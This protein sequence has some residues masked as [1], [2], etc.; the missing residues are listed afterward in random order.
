MAGHAVGIR[1]NDVRR[2][3]SL[4]R[5][6]IDIVVTGPAGLRARYRGEIAGL[7]GLGITGVV[8]GGTE[9][10]PGAG[11]RRVVVTGIG[12]RIGDRGEVRNGVL[13]AEYIVMPARH[14]ARQVRPHVD[15]VEHHLEVER[16]AAGRID[17]T[18]V[19]ADHAVLH[20]RAR[21]AMES[22]LVVA[23]RAGLIVHQVVRG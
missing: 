12:L 11:D 3:V 4:A 21:A 14:D 15:L 1:G 5:H 2:A 9:A 16:I 19:V 6:E 22:E 18:R 7:R 17:G 13:V 10:L 20:F 23:A 8:A